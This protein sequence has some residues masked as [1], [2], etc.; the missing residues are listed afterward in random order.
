MILVI[1]FGVGHMLSVPTWTNA[2][3]VN[4]IAILM[5]PVSTHLDPTFVHAR[6]ATSVTERRFVNAPASKIASMAVALAHLISSAN[7]S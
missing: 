1:L 7:A 4:T 2:P 3:W 6:K 5:Q